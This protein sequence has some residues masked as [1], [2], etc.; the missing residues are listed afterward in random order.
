MID[1]HRFFK[2]PFDNRNISVAELSRFGADHLNR[3]S[4]N[5]TG[6]FLT[7]RI[8]A[9][10]A[11][12]T[13]VESGSTSDQTKLAIRKAQVQAKDNFRENLPRDIQKIYG[14]VTGFYGGD[15]AQLTEIFPEGRTVFTSCKDTE[16]ENKLGVLIAGITAHQADLGAA[17]VAQATAL[18]T[19]WE[20]IYNA[21]MGSTSAKG[22]T[23]VA[24]KAA[25]ETLQLELFRNLLTIA[26]QFPGEPE[27]LDVYMK[28]NLLENPEQS[29]DETPTPPPTP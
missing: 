4:D 7:T 22:T 18:R 10:T 15:C 2:N 6:G 13:A 27:R 1:M 12:L 28:Q 24:M 19:N 9:T 3:M 5:N 25:R 11:A 14:M 20:A 29:D 23:Q 26:L 16:L 21:S 17:L 8:A